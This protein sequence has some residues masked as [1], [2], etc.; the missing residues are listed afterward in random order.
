MIH[1]AKVNYLVS[2][3]TRLITMRSISILLLCLGTKFVQVVGAAK[4]S[5]SSS[6]IPNP[7]APPSDKFCQSNSLGDDAYVSIFKPCE[8]TFYTTDVT[9]EHFSCD[10][11]DDDTKVIKTED[12]KVVMWPDSCVAAGP[13]CYSLTHYP[14]LSNFTFYQ[15][16]DYSMEFPANATVVSVDCTAD[17]AKAQEFL[18]NLPE[19]LGEVAAAICWVAVVFSIAV[20]ACIVAC[21]CCCF[22]ACRGRREPRHYMAIPAHAWR[23]APPVEAAV[24]S[25]QPPE[26]FLV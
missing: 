24:L 4:D 11:Y 5:S 18:D 12:R 20:V 19:E 6:A 7:F 23:G 22:G 3:S 17:F 21:I 1:K 14:E 10:A 8:F 13:R 2:I 16:T 15:D 25:S 26:K 9:P